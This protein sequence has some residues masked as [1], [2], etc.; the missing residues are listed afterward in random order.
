MDPN[1]LYDAINGASPPQAQAVPVDYAGLLGYGTPSPALTPAAP[2]VPD[3]AVTS[4]EQVPEGGPSNAAPQA[5]APGQSLGVGAKVSAQGYSPE[6][7][8]QIQKNH[9]GL[10]KKIDQERLLA[11]Q[12]YAGL[13]AQG[14]E[15]SSEA[16]QAALHEAN[17]E[18]QKLAA[19]SDA[20][21]QIASAQKDFMAKE[22]AAVDNSKA[23]ADAAKLQYRAALADYAAA[24]VNPGQLWE[25]SGAGGQFA[26][27]ATAFAHDF[28]GAKGIQTSGLDSIN[29]AIQ[30]NI[31]AQLENMR[32]KGDVAQGFKQLWDMQRAQSTTDTEARQRMN[33]FYLAA[34]SNQIE[35]KLGGYD[36]QLALAKGQ[37][38]KA[39]LMQEQVKNDLLV[40]QH[41][42][43]AA[44]QRAQQKVEV[45]KTD[46]AASSAK[47][48]A[49]AHLKAALIAAQAKEKPVNP[50]SGAFVDTSTSGQNEVKRR[51]LPDVKPEVQSKI[52]ESADKT[53]KTSENIQK[54]IELQR[55]A[56]S[57]IPGDFATLNK[58]Q[59]EEKRVAE[60]V[61]NLVKMGIIYDNSGKQI[62][63]QE[64]KLYD[65]LVAKDDW[66]VTGDNVRQLA[67]IS[68]V[69]LD[70][71]KAIIA[72]STVAIQPGDP[73]YGFKTGSTANIAPGESAEADIQ[74]QPGGGKPDATE[75]KAHIKAAQSPDAL[76]SVRIDDLPEKGS[77]GK[78]QVAHD[79]QLFSKEQPWA[80]PNE[81][82]KRDTERRKGSKDF[83]YSIATAGPENPDKVFIELEKLADLALSGD[84]EA[85][86]TIDQW[87]AG[88]PST[89]DIG[90]LLAA[91][92]QWEKSS[93]GL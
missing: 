25:A 16:Q 91:Y 28:L 63:E 8:A 40:Q 17:I 35:S 68:K 19:T 37:A 67:T 36:S 47:Y 23:E 30:N 6:A 54:L 93:K 1:Q 49:D 64:M 77:G 21:L 57:V 74:S 50:L 83:L 10:D 69:N 14:A 4:P 58:L 62:N 59:N 89:A 18:S 51:F 20:K 9:T 12:P 29:K 88:K 2:V 70:K 42:D 55:A 76:E 60:T 71:V 43:Q 22:Q 90:G 81:N 82:D 92:A 79:W 84:T 34:L 46:V 65:Q 78:S 39:A 24:K 73:A 66:F 15:A 31:N 86:K 38:A 72:G 44:N 41:I 33:G 48:T 45:Y 80:V 27:I 61:R 5:L 53:F 3:A 32:K 7:Y 56:G 85:K 52:Q 26:M 87:A 11:A 75:A 13:Q